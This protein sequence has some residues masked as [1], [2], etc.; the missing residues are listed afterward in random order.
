MERVCISASAEFVT[1]L[2]DIVRGSSKIRNSVF[3]IAIADDNRDAILEFLRKECAPSAHF[4]P[5]DEQDEYESIFAA[6]AAAAER[7]LGPLGNSVADLFPR[8]P[9]YSVS[10]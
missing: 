9:S 2:S 6:A 8:K 10:S 7:Y 4:L 3:R 5:P 1:S